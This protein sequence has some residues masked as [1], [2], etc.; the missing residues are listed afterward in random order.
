M[1]S[2]DDRTVE[3][4]GPLW[5]TIVHDIGQLSVTSN[6]LSSSS[7]I[8]CST[9]VVS[10]STISVGEH[11]EQNASTR[12]GW[13]AAL[14]AE[15]CDRGCLRPREWLLPP[16]GQGAGEVRDAAG[17]RRRRHLGVHGRSSARLLASVV[18]SRCCGFRRIGHVRA[19][20]RASGPSGSTQAHPG[21]RRVPSVRGGIGGNSRRRGGNALWRPAAPKDGGASPVVTQFWPSLTGGAQGEYEMLRETVLSTG[22]TP[23][24]LAA[25]RLLRRGLAGLIT[26]PVTE[27]VF[28][29]EVIGAR[30][31]AWTPQTDPRLE[32]LAESFE[33]LVSVKRPLA[34]RELLI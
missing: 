29:G 25:A 24:T 8:Q 28:V 7:G 27:P 5:L 3:D 9:S 26:W 1:S 13:A 11:G 31:P 15:C 10:G 17:P 6:V 12:A 22:T 30:R 18:L 16:G 4:C 20:R 34:A 23:D 2:Q 14:P 19:G 32:A 33:L 21:D